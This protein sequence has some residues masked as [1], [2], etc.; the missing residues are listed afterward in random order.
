MI[1]LTTTLGEYL[2]DY[3]TVISHCGS[4]PAFDKLDRALWGARNHFGTDQNIPY[5]IGLKVAIEIATEC[6]GFDKLLIDKLSTF[7]IRED[8]P[9]KTEKGNVK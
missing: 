5:S 9:T 4:H 6:E 1:I 8:K 2:T 3:D 7:A